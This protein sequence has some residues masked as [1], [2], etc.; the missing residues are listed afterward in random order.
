MARRSPGARARA[1]GVTFER[2]IAA[3]LRRIYDPPELVEQIATAN[4]KTRPALM[5][6]SSVRRG[7]QRGGAREPDLV[8][9]SHWWLEL[10]CAA[11]NRG[12]V[13]ASDKLEQAIRDSANTHWIWPAVV[14]RRKGSPLVWVT[15]QLVTLADAMRWGVEPRPRWPITLSWDNFEAI[16]IEDYHGSRKSPAVANS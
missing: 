3:G 5:Q 11:E 12:R 6:Q 10:H 15:L 1:T 2:Q 9:P 16:L 13:N 4:A 7:D 8:T 14:F